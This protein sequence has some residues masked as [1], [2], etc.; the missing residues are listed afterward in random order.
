[1]ESEFDD[2]F[3]IGAYE[4][5]S[6]SCVL[7]YDDCSE[8]CDVFRLTVRERETNMEHSIVWSEVE[9]IEKKDPKH[10]FTIHPPDFVAPG[11]DLTEEQVYEKFYWLTVPLLRY[12]ER[13][14]GWIFEKDKDGNYVVKVSDDIDYGFDD[15]TMKV[16]ME[17][18]GGYRGCSGIDPAWC[19]KSEGAMGPDGEFETNRIDIVHVVANLPGMMDDMKTTKGRMDVLEERTDE[20]DVD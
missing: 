20:I 5:D 10:V 13:K 15:I 12:L 6:M 17:W 4:S 9:F 16:F 1:M 14:A 2:R 7:T 11:R 18:M 8:Y 19:D 3:S